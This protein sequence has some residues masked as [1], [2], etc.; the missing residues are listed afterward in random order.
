MV[1]VYTLF[2][3][4]LKF[5]HFNMLMLSTNGSY[6][7][8]FIK[9]LEEYH[10]I[11]FILPFILGYAVSYTALSTTK[12][13]MKDD[14]DIIGKRL[15]VLTS[16]SLA[17]YFIKNKQIVEKIIISSVGIIGYIIIISLVLASCCFATGKDIS[18]IHPFVRV[19]LLLAFLAVIFPAYFE[20]FFLIAEKSI[21]ISL[22]E[23]TGGVFTIIIILLGIMGLFM[24]LVSK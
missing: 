15:N 4:I 23:V 9:A 3:K 13:L 24:H 1:N 21:S 12:I 20:I 2:N 16:F 14:N 11:D 7:E 19:I 6:S 18:Q 10:I 22:F 5:I 8:V 17:I